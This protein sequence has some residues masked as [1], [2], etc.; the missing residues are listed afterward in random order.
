MRDEKRQATNPIRTDL[1]ATNPIRTHLKATNPIR[2]HLKATNP[3]RHLDWLGAG[4]GA[5]FWN[6]AI[7]D[8]ILRSLSVCSSEQR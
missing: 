3:I 1:K 2:T 8:L 5:D 7:F 6:F 4:A